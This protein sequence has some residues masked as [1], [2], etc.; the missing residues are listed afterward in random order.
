MSPASPHSLHLHALGD[1]DNKVD[2]GV[3]VVVGAAGRIHVQVCHAHVLGV[4][5]HILRGDEH[6]KLRGT[7]QCS[8]Y[9]MPVSASNTDTPTP[10]QSG[11]YAD[12]SLGAAA[13]ELCRPLGAAGR[14]L[15]IET[16]P[17]NE[18][19]LPLLQSAEEG[20]AGEWKRIEE[21]EQRAGEEKGE[22]E[23]VRGREARGRRAGS[24]KKR[25]RKRERKKKRERGE[26]EE[27]RV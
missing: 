5:L 13:R 25:A 9:A 7:A 1:V 23:G 4:G 12:R 14:E 2:V 19:A 24:E 17:A 8:R 15:R 3:V 6:H 20:R 27:E 26:G 21:K 16:A 22:G 18:A 11:N 10:Q